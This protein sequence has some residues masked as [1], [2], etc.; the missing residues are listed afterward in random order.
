MDDTPTVD[1]RRDSI[2]NIRSQSLSPGHESSLRKINTTINKIKNNVVSE[3]DPSVLVGE[4]QTMNFGKYMDEISALFAMELLPKKQATILGFINLIAIFAGTYSEFYPLF[5]S[6]WENYRLKSYCNSL[7]CGPENTDKCI[8]RLIVEMNICGFSEFDNDFRLVLDVLCLSQNPQLYFSLVNYLCRLVTK[9][10]RGCGTMSRFWEIFDS[11]THRFDQI[12]IREITSTRE[13]VTSLHKKCRQIYETK[14]DL[15]QP[16]SDYFFESYDCFMAHLE[17]YKEFCVSNGIDFSLNYWEVEKPRTSNDGRLIFVDVFLSGEEKNTCFESPEE[18]KFYTDL[19]ISLSTDMNL[20]EFKSL[21]SI[22]EKLTCQSQVDALALV[23]LNC[24]DEMYSYEGF[25]DKIIDVSKQRF[26]LIPAIA[27]FFALIRNNYPEIVHS[28]CKSILNQ[29]HFLINKRSAIVAMRNRM[30]SLI[31][32]FC[33]FGLISETDTFL[34]LRKSSDNLDKFKLELI[35]LILSS[36]GRYLYFSA[37]SRKRIENIIRVLKRKASSMFPIE[38]MSLD[39][40]VRNILGIDPETIANFESVESMFLSRF[41]CD[42]VRCKNLDF[43]RKVADC[44]GVEILVESLVNSRLLCYI[45]LSSVLDIVSSFNSDDYSA[46]IDMFSESI[47]MEVFSFPFVDRQVVLKSVEFLVFEVNAYKISIEDFGSFVEQLT[48]VSPAS[49]LESEWEDMKKSLV[50][51]IGGSIKVDISYSTF[52]HLLSSAHKKDD[53]L[54][55][56]S[57]NALNTSDPFDGCL[58][59]AISNLS[60]AAMESKKTSTKMKDETIAYIGSP[61]KEKSSSRTILL[62]Q[63]GR[64][65]ADLRELS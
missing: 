41:L 32:E 2:K 49:I 47:L 22:F 40:V 10:T 12:Y 59:E 57:L 42:S 29:T 18:L 9:C 44:I 53:A 13:K 7:K 35:I 26:D 20:P 55:D 16:Q 8:L 54:M 36:C 60:I 61:V 17:S 52:S 28:A 63:K 64:K 56:T 24:R 6:K 62:R 19:S 58:D 27:R 25:A 3:Q 21:G 1:Q 50:D 11:F 14:G 4:V 48:S 23:A 38:Y 51:L 5:R 45:P 65:V 46:F 39:S 34:I 15:S 30:A 37:S 31:G 33:K 43:C